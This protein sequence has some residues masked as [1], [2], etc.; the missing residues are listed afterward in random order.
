M[1]AAHRDPAEER[2]EPQDLLEKEVLVIGCGNVMI[3]DDGLGPTFIKH[4]QDRGGVPGHVGLLDAGTGVR[5]LLFGMV[6]SDPK[7]RR[8]VV[9]DAVDVGR[10]PGEVFEIEL[11]AVPPQKSDDFSLHQLPTSNMLKELRDQ[12]GVEVR[13]IAVQVSF[14]PQELQA[15]LSAPVE[16]SLERVR[17]LVERFY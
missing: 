4:L 12:C 16:G 11:D 9:V 1:E 15:G 6:L 17:E 3:G 14:L 2:P 10:P 8:I 5:S 13:V 7:P